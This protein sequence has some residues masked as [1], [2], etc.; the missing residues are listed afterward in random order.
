ME[1]ENIQPEFVCLRVKGSYKTFGKNVL[2]PILGINAGSKVGL[3]YKVSYV[4]V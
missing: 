3:F 4:G 2:R 1:R